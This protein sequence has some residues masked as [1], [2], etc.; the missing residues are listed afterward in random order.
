MRLIVFARRAAGA[1]RV[2]LSGRLVIATAVGLLL[3]LMAGAF[4]AGVQLGSGAALE[5]MSAGGI[6]RSALQQKRELED[7][8]ARVQE[9]SLI[10][11]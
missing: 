8:R 3:S 6:A 11:I 5:S 1:S 4:Y 10:H 7:L 2:D 9:L